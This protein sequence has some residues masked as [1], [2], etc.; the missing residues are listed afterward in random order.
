MLIQTV[1]EYYM[2]TKDKIFIHN[3][4][5][6]LEKEYRFW[7]TNRSVTVEHEGKKY[8]LNRYTV[9]LTNP[10]PEGYAEDLEVT[11]HMSPE[12]AAQAYSDIA[13]SAESGVDFSTRWFSWEGEYADKMKSIRTAQVIPVDLNSFLLWN[14]QLLAKFADMIGKI[15]VKIFL[16]LLF[17]LSPLQ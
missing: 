2:A 6:T 14:E 15:T 11:E 9:D 12:E 13:A 5:E 10:R 3:N 16:L 8:H 4:F 7:K 1:Y 17:S